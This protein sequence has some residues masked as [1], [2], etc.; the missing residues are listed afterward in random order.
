MNSSC[1][2][3]DYCVN[4]NKRFLLFFG[5]F[6][7]GMIAG[8]AFALDL[9]AGISSDMQ[10]EITQLQAEVIQGKGRLDLEP[11]DLKKAEVHVKQNEGPS[12]VARSGV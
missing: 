5:L 7:V 8:P 3:G 10:R 9:P 4:M 6:S 11:Q 1:F 12:R 2:N